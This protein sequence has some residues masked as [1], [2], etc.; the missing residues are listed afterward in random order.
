MDRCVD[1]QRHVISRVHFSF[2]DLI[3]STFDDAIQSYFFIAF[4]HLIT[5]LIIRFITLVHKTFKVSLLLAD[6]SLGAVHLLRL[7]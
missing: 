1:E 3:N 5:V 7:V 4:Y 6:L 2:T